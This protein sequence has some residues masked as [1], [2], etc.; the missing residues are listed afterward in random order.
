MYPVCTLIASNPRLQR[1]RSAPLRSPLSRKTLADLKK[2]D[3]GR[4]RTCR[5]SAFLIV[6]GYLA[7]IT[8]PALARSLVGASVS[9]RDFE[10]QLNLSQQKHAAARLLRS[11]P[12]SQRAERAFRQL[13]DEDLRLYGPFDGWVMED[14][15]ALARIL[16]SR[17][18]ERRAEQFYG[19]I[20]GLDLSLNDQQRWDLE[21]VLTNLLAILDSTGRPPDVEPF[22]WRL[23]RLCEQSKGSGH[24]DLSVI[25]RYIGMFYK[26]EDR[27]AVAEPVFRRSL[28]ILTALWGPASPEVAEDLNQIAIAREVQCDFR[29]A[30]V[31]YLQAT[32]TAAV[33]PCPWLQELPRYLENYAGM[34]ASVGRLAEARQVME[35]QSRARRWVYW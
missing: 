9:P 34:L 7:V 30:E 20:L 3:G 22:L 8:P 31:L 15:F 2:L 16:D 32:A 18:Q 19:R 33:S 27:Y 4:G 6:F 5:A 14:Y 13:L 23:E 10:A 1:T 29:S 28:A 26:A 12:Q 24:P 21:E 17:G 25:L 11:H 35:E